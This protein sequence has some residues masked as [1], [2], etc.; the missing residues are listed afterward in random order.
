MI[1]FNHGT[2]R[3][4]AFD[5]QA[6][7]DAGIVAENA[8]QERRQ[9]LG[10]S[11]LGE[12]CARAL[13]YEYLGTPKDKSFTGRTYR[14]FEAGHRM[15]DAAIGWIRA[16]GFDLRTE[17][18]GKQ[19]GFEVADGRIR[20]HIDGVVCGGPAGPFPYLFE[21]KALGDKSWKDVV[22][23]G[24]AVSKPV[25]AAQVAMYQAYMDLTEHP[26][27]FMATNRDSLEV[28]VERIPYNARLAQETS[29]KG[30]AILRACDDGETMP[31]AYMEPESFG[32]R[33]CDYRERCWS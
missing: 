5:W 2:T 9:Y 3:K 8:K 24:V 7:I 18:G 1:D 10:G 12:A 27:L 30:V 15:E 31:R 23:K 4:E 28:Y 25:Y 6:A 29:D 14:I 16:A 20:G 21:H 26:A 33:F 13:Q 17:K 11:R 22:K 19:F 32:C